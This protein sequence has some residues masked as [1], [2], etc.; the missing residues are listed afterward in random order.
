M[1]DATSPL[2]ARMTGSRAA[3]LALAVLPVV[4]AS[5]LG[6]LATRANIP[7][8]YAGLE[9]PFFTPPNWVFAPVWTVLF[10]MIALAAYRI[11]SVPRDHPGRAGA[12]WAYGAQLVLNTA[13]SVAFFGLRS[14]GLGLIVIAL[15][16]AAIALTIRRFAPL[17]RPAA[18]LLAPYLAWV[19]YASAL[20]LAIWWLNR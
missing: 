11:L 16:I 20:N 9:K 4:A 12:L 8:W 10:A 7:T 14:P 18:W 3:R 19:S 13:W 15:L 6:S 17:D 1:R 2:A 5:A